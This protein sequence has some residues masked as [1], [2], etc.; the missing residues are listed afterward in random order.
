MV[1]PI[2]LILLAVFLWR[3]A[4]TYTNGFSKIVMKYFSVALFLVGISTLGQG[5]IALSNAVR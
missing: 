2:V 1:I 3:R 5:I 4:N